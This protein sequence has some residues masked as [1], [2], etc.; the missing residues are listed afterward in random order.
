MLTRLLV[1]TAVIAAF[2]VFVPTSSAQTTTQT[3]TE[4]VDV[5]DT[6]DDPVLLRDCVDALLE[7][8]GGGGGSTSTL[9]EECQEIIGEGTGGDTGGTGGNTGGTGGDS[10]D[11]STGGG[12][13]TGSLLDTLSAGQLLQLVGCLN[14]LA[15]LDDGEDDEQQDAVNEDGGGTGDNGGLGEGDVGFGEQGFGDEG[16]GDDGDFPEGGIESG[17]GPTGSDEAGAPLA[18]RGVALLALL[19]VLATGLVVMRRRSGS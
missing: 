9:P 13:L 19:G 10:T 16:G 14:A 15:G 12:G 5:T 8:T 1:L 18:A 17:Y 4:C 7:V 6:T 3:P 11:G 2:F